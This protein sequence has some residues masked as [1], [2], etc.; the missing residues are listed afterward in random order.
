LKP[1]LHAHRMFYGISSTS[2]DMGNIV[3]RFDAPMEEPSTQF[4]GI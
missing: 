3:V 4:L 2:Y 1:P